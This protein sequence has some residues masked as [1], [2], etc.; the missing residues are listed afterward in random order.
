MAEATYRELEN[1]GHRR[2]AARGR[3]DPD[4]DRT[5]P[6]EQWV[7]PLFGVTPERLAAAEQRTREHCRTE[8][9]RR[10][11]RTRERD[12]ARTAAIE[13]ARRQLRTV[14]HPHS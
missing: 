1:T 5:H 10:W 7:A 8:H 2:R 9:E 14:L 3:Y 4:Q 13:E 11:E 6:W 12:P